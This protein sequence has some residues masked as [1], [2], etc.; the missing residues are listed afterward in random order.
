MYASSE[1]K[2]YALELWIQDKHLLA[3]ANKHHLSNAVSSSHALV[4]KPRLIRLY[5]IPRM[6]ENVKD[7]LH[8]S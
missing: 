4:L 7:E 2:I 6:A 3:C 1:N 5:S 8:V